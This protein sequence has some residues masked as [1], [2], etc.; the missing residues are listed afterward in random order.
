MTVD[1]DKPTGLPQADVTGRHNYPKLIELFNACFAERDYR[2]GSNTRL[3]CGQGEPI[4]YP[5]GMPEEDSGHDY[6]RIIFAH[7]FFASALH[8]LAHWCV[9]GQERRCLVD[10]GYWYIPDGRTAAQQQAFER[11]EGR[12]Q[13]IEWLLASACD[14]RFCVSVDNLTGEAGD[15][16]GFKALVYQYLQGYLQ[17]GVNERTQCLINAF[18]TH[19]G[20][21]EPMAAERF[22]LDQ[23]S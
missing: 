21:K 17:A 18:S 12:T 13:A 2:D 20:V 4:Y 15:S 11:V 6:H 8:E 19:F 16:Q 10:F 22:Q 14:Y 23:L 5:A 9:A 7:G 3:I 1:L